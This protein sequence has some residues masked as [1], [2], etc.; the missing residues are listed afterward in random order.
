MNK[1]SALTI[2]SPPPVACV[3]GDVRPDLIR[4]EVLFEL[5][6][7]TVH[8]TPKAIAIV[9]QERKFTYQEVDRITNIMASH[10]QSKGISVGD[11]VGHW[12]N[13]S[14][15]LIM[16]QIAITKTGAA[17]LPFD[18]QTPLDR[19]QI[20]LSDASAKCLVTTAQGKAKT[21]TFKTTVYADTELQEFEKPVA[22]PRRPKNLTPDQ[23]AY[24][25]YTSGSSGTPKGVIAS[26]A[27]ACHYLRAANEVVQFQSTD[28]IFQGTS[29][30]FDLSIEE[31]WLPF[32]VGA[33]LVVAPS[34]IMGD[35]EKIS[36]LVNKN[37]ITIMDTVPTLL[38][39]LN[40]EM[41]SLRMIILGGEPLPVAL[42]RRLARP[43]RKIFNAY[44]PTEATIGAT[45]SQ[46]IPLQPVTIGRPYPNYTCY[47]VDPGTN[48]LV[49]MGG[50]KGEL[51]IGGPGV[52]CGYLNRP[53]LT[54]EKF[55]PN[56]FPSDGSDR[57]LYK[58][59]DEVF[60]DIEGNIHFSG[61][62]DDQIK[63]RGF[64]IELGEIEATLETLEDIASCSAI[65][66]KESGI[67]QLVAFVVLKQGRRLND[68]MTRQYLG[69]TLPPYMIPNH[70]ETLT[71]LPKNPSGKVNRKALTSMP[72][73][74]QNQNSNLEPPLDAAELF[75]LT[76]AKQ[77]FPL[78]NISMNADFFND[79]GGHSLLAAQFIS[80][81]RKNPHFAAIHLQ[82]IYELRTLQKIAAA[83][84]SSKK[85]VPKDFTFQAP[86][87]KSRF[88][89]GL[90]QALFIPVILFLHTLQWLG[91]FVGSL[92]LHIEK[93]SL[94]NQILS[95]LGIYILINF[96]V[97]MI[98]LAGKW[99][100]I[101]RTK[102][103]IYPLWGFYYFRWW[104]AAR[105][106]SLV[107]FKW[108]QNTPL[109]GL[110][111]RLLGAKVGKEAIISEFEAGAIDLITIGDRVVTGAKAK[112]SNA[113]VMGNQLYIGHIQIANDAMI[114]TSALLSSDS[115]VGPF[116]EVGDLSLIEIGTIVP[117]FQ[118]WQGSPAKKVGTSES[119]PPPPKLSKVRS[120]SMMG[121]YF[122]MFLL[123]PVCG[124]LPILPAIW[125]LDNLEILI[126]GLTKAD[127][128]KY[129]P[130]LAIPSAAVFLILTL[131]MLL[132]L[133][134]L[135]LPRR[136]KPGSY[137]VHSGVFFR[138]W[139]LGLATEVNIDTLTSLLVTVY[140]SPFYRMMGAK[141]GKGTEICT[142][143]N[144]FYD[145]IDFGSQNFIADD[146]LIGD[147]N[148]RQGSVILKTVKTGQRVFIGNDA[149]VPHGTVMSDDSLLGV[150]S[151][152]P[153]H[154]RIEQHETW[155]GSPSLLIP[156]RQKMKAETKWTYNPTKLRKLARALFELVP[157]LTPNALFIIFGYSAVSI[158]E[159]LIRQ[160]RSWS[161]FGL[162]LLAS[163][164]IPLA[165]IFISIGLKWLFVGKYKPC[166]N[167]M[168]SSFSMR[169]EAT[170][171]L[172]WQLAGKS[173]LEPFR[174]TPILPFILR[175]FGAKIGQGVYMNSS[176]I[177]EFDCVKIGS[178]ANINSM[179]VLQ[180]HLYEDRI[181]KIGTI[182]IGQGV[183]I[184]S[185]STILYD[186]K[187]GNYSQLAGLTVVMKGEDLPSQTAWMGS[188]C[189]PD[190]RTHAS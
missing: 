1:I 162:F 72:L 142:H 53:Q 35:G 98:G 117:E 108:M 165:M 46:V 82:D 90:A 166:V 158:L 27:N 85:V 17:W 174:G 67:D 81:L 186:T 74:I 68:Q 57:V 59:G 93:T 5:F 25:I 159:I 26:H 42:A 44:G 10:L 171:S 184:G 63:L 140:L 103:G 91:V 88:F 45:I 77:I 6:A 163:C 54:A 124:L 78:Q 173:T 120:R 190:V 125:I 157:I 126:S 177:T 144:S 87:L 104:M 110:T 58:T 71:E 170:T 150:K 119:Q 73:K 113:E 111:M 180:T 55:I 80:H 41:P 76:T 14:A 168:W 7:A 123:L 70:F 153:E 121:L 66:R 86:S 79:L 183:S 28:V 37:K 187:I 128:L 16:I 112:F 182:E 149:I 30:A 107:K 9:D 136:L 161:V 160:D 89:C 138:K 141:I 69:Q 23:P 133:R 96:L 179:T 164:L 32:M 155:F 48:D 114:G 15:E 95:L 50:E 137:S 49:S 39:M 156:Q 172:Y 145:L 8:R 24:V 21:K 181:M 131:F 64:R 188:P 100:C 18:E 33:S 52:S 139:L 175:L 132:T 109:M 185:G 169:S 176:D 154:L 11:I 20:C 127:T 99:L 36:D 60:V 83:L 116:S 4:N 22:L 65:V 105:F 62:I 34:G 152:P 135:I 40:Q 143:L 130:L 19:I 129:L 115:S 56:P 31:I 12:M 151:T 75:L 97:G 167:P 178:Y 118:I 61:R 148:I 134:W 84:K 122:S 51:L 94:Q 189:E 146:A 106:I 92:L 3:R 2:E 147:E 102:P 29:A 38:T 101:G 47:I 13:R 43:G